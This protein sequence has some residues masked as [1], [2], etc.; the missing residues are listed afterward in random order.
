M[1]CTQP[2]GPGLDGLG[3]SEILKVLQLAKI[4]TPDA[5]LHVGAY[6]I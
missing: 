3:L 1:Y 6:S 4:A 2:G 5:R